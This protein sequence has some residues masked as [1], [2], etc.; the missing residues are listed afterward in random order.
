MLNR[1]PLWKNLLIFFV[2]AFGVLYA[3]PNIF[4]QDPA[5]QIA[6]QTSGENV[7]QRVLDQATR[8]LEGAGIEFIRGELGESAAL[9][10]LH[11]AEDQLPAKRAIESALGGDYVVALNRVTTTPDWLAS[12]G[13]QPLKLGLD[14]AGGVHFLLEVDTD[15]AI[16]KRQETTASEIRRLLRADR[17]RYRSVDLNR[18][19]VIVARFSDQEDRSRADTIVRRELPEL[20]RVSRNAGDEYELR[21]NLTEL[22]V[23]EIEDYAV[24]QNLTTLRNRV[25]E[26]GVSE[27]LVAKQGSNRIVVELPGVQDTTEAKRIIGRTAN[28]EF[29]LEAEPGGLVS[30]KEQ[31]EYMDPEEQRLRGGVWLEE[32]III[33]GDSVANAQAGFDSRDNRPQVSITLDSAGGTRMSMATR[34]NVGRNMGTLFIETK[35]ETSYRT[36][37]DGE[38]VP[39]VRQTQDKKIISLAN[40]REPLGVRFQITGLD[41]PQYAS[42][43]ALLL[44][45]GALAAPMTF[46]EEH[47]IGPSLGQQN[48]DAGVTSILIGMALVVVFM[49]AYYKVFGIAANFA[50]AMN[51]VLIA[52]AMSILG[53]TLTLPGMAG[54]VLTVGMAVDANV[55]IFSRIREELRNGMSPQQAI[56]AGFDRAFV[57][58]MDANI[59]TLIVAFIL[60]GIGT[61]PVKGFAVTLSI[62]ILTSMFT[63]IM[64]TRAIVNFAYGGRRVKTL[65]I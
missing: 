32:D 35:T 52:A 46:V 5:V 36:N 22:A 39:V 40:I 59:T 3:L 57:T 34:N 51:V 13:G 58:I 20:E 37:E 41:S 44:R 49:L 56:N 63:A 2:V 53:A 48:I 26:I 8:A 45:S 17:V 42:E 62:G 54:I 64:G 18:D 15:A 38:Q 24:N 28:L 60:W 1:Y 27:P 43:L 31:F 25:N 16:E 7:S 33:T 21:M 12:I 14:L 23:Q 19:G 4:P 61:G 29:R 11:E 10:R 47:T 55:L 6:S 30:S 50:L 9:I 65:S